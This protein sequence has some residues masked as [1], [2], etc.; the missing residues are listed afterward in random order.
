MKDI[1]D[2][3][4]TTVELQDLPSIAERHEETHLIQPDI[5]AWPKEPLPIEGDRISR[6]VNKLI[7]A[8]LLTISAALV[9]KAGLVILAWRPNVPVYVPGTPPL[10]RTVALANLYNLNAQL[11]TLF[12][13][14]FVTTVSTLLR[15]YA[16]W[17][18]QKG[19]YI[20]ELEQLQG[21][22]SVTSTLT[23]IWSLRSWSTTSVGLVVVWTFYYLG[24]QA[25]KREL[26]PVNSESFHSIPLG[27]MGP[28]Y[29]SWFAGYTG[30]YQTGAALKSADVGFASAVQFSQ[31]LVSRPGMDIN[32]N[33]LVPDINSILQARPDAI[34]DSRLPKYYG[35]L[36]VG[37]QTE[38]KMDQ[39]YASYTGQF[40]A[41][42]ATSSRK[43]EDATWWQMLGDYNYTTSYFNIN[44][45]IPIFSIY[46]TFV[47]GTLD[48]TRISLNMTP[49]STTAPKDI[50]GNTIRSFDYWVRWSTLDGDYRVSTNGSAHSVCNISSTLVDVRVN[51]LATGCTPL[52]VRYHNWSSKEVATNYS[53]FFDNDEY[54]AL[55]LDRFVSQ[56]SVVAQATTLSYL[57]NY[58][59]DLASDLLLNVTTQNLNPELRT[60][61][62]TY[63]TATQQIVSPTAALQPVIFDPINGL[64]PTM[65]WTNTTLTGAQFYPHY[66]LS[67][68]WLA[69]DFVSSIIL[70]LAAVASVW[71][72]QKILVP[73]IFGYVSSLTRDNVY[74]QNVLPDNGSG[75]T[76]IERARIMKNVK[77]KIGDVSGDDSDVARIG[78]TVVRVGDSDFEASPE[79]TTAGPLRENM[80]I[81]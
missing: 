58:N 27:F 47:N 4:V 20:S 65:I 46:E 10:A 19:S 29:P 52:A 17:K 78:M 34:Y 42:Y 12:T 7:D 59:T 22:M 49:I 13:I 62:N 51:C 1:D 35:W 9:V 37:N 15:R 76:G 18:A 45:S 14:I 53:T 23:L 44:C 43:I 38:A 66:A 79:V 26:M 55:F 69:L 40:P 2:T 21:S 56:D 39:H 74:L 75:L 48:S 25:N 57:Q 73:D 41:V 63:Y 11:I 6:L 80:Q 68:L 36:S 3:A 54:A 77:V 32:G 28:N 72:R 16:L 67:Y 8:A 64:D 70:F 5:E 60:L 61:L 50:H 24:S 33:A 71:L 31:A 81:V 30:Q